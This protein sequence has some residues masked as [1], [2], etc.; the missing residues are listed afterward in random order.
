MQ[1]KIDEKMQE[2]LFFLESIHSYGDIFPQR[3]LL[4]WLGSN[5]LIIGQMA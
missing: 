5:H 2:L 1:M 3:F 4:F